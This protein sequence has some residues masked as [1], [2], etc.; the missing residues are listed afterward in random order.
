MCDNFSPQQH[1]HLTTII[2]IQGQ[3]NIELGGLRDTYANAEETR[4]DLFTPLG[5]FDLTAGDEVSVEISNA[6]TDGY[7][8]ADCVQLVKK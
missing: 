7:L 3:W 6:D 4:D 1:L 8:V 5:M 2:E